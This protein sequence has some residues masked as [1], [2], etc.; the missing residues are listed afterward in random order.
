[1][2]ACPSDRLREALTF[3]LLK[4]QTSV[5][6]VALFSVCSNFV[7][8]L[9]FSNFDLLKLYVAARN[10]QNAPLPPLEPTVCNAVSALG[11]DC[12]LIREHISVAFVTHAGV[13]IP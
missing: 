3:V 10:T 9:F 7:V 6:D 8:T 4:P 13:N 2:S 1:M 12:W 11:G 5:R